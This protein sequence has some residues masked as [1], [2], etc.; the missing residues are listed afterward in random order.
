MFS[1]LCAL[2]A[3]I[4][5]TNY[6]VSLVSADVI[7]PSTHILNCKDSS[8][9]QS[10][11]KVSVEISK[12]LSNTIVGSSSQ[13]QQCR[14]DST[15][16]SKLYEKNS[17]QGENNKVTQNTEQTDKCSNSICEERSEQTILDTNNEPSPS[18]PL[19]GLKGD[20]NVIDKQTKQNNQCNGESSK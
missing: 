16:D 2:L 19:V 7:F 10:S 9:F 4:F 8:C 20:N 17:V 5:V 18:N 14:D 15:C 13:I 11:S 3:T 6:P 12:T 1:T